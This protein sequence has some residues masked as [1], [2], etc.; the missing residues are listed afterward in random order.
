MNEFEMIIFSASIGTFIGYV[1]GRIEGH[2]RGLGDNYEVENLI[3]KS[4]YENLKAKIEKVSGEALTYFYQL[5]ELKTPAKPKDIAITMESP[6]AIRERFDR[7]C[8][9]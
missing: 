4:K 9:L 7:E 5:E 8:E 1:V 6:E 3:I 2:K